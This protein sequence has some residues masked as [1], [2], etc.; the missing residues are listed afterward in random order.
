MVIKQ[1][2]DK[3]LGVN[4][5]NEKI[6]DLLIPENVQNLQSEYPSEDIASMA[7]INR[8]FEQRDKERDFFLMS[9]NPDKQIL[10]DFDR[11]DM[12]VRGLKELRANLRKAQ[13][14]CIHTDISLWQSYEEYIGKIETLIRGLEGQGAVIDEEMI[15]ERFGPKKMNM[16]DSAYPFAKLEQYLMEHPELGYTISHNLRIRDGNGQFISPQ[17]LYEALKESELVE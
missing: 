1:A 2:I 17:K 11:V 13:G 5:Q 9:S 7:R 4:A 15:D 10:I 6:D 14:N 8:F 3:I 16:S 12:V